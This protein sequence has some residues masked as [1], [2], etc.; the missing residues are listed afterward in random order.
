[1]PRRKHDVFISHAWEDKDAIARPLAE[2][3]RKRGLDVWYDEFSLRVGDRLRGSID[4]GL[5]NSQFGV[6]ILSPRF[7]AKEWPRR[8]LDGLVAEETGRKRKV[9]LPVWHE[10]TQADVRKFSPTLA[11]TVAAK[12]SDGVDRVAD[13]IMEAIPPRRRRTQAGRLDFTNEDPGAPTLPG[14]LLVHD[15]RAPA[16]WLDPI[17]RP[18]GPTPWQR[19]QPESPLGEPNKQPRG[20]A[21]IVGLR[22]SSWGQYDATVEWGTTASMEVR[23]SLFRE[24]NRTPERT[25]PMTSLGLPGRVQT[26]TFRDLEP[27]TTYRIVA[28]SATDRQEIV[29]ETHEG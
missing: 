28:E 1:M 9:I 8:E 11:L 25:V 7:F 2:E 13:Q 14:P 4:R 29:L 18:E 23:V 19:A 6:V 17:G 16:P 10:V 5:A 22:V 12:S 26:I 20:D 3:L 27:G 21:R 24:G 15:T